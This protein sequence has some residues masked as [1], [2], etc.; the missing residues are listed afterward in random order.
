MGAE[1][2]LKVGIYFNARVEQGGLYQYALTLVDCLYRYVPEYDYLLYHA[3]LEKFP[4]QIL[5]DNWRLIQLPRLAIGFRMVLE[6]L[7]NKLAQFGL[8]FPL[9]LIPR[10]KQ[11]SETPPDIMVYVKPT[12]H[13]FEWPYGAIFPIHDLQHRL[14]PEFPEVSDH[15][16]FLRREFLYTHSIEKA[17]AI[18]TDSQTGKEDVL[19]LYSTD[20]SKIYPLPYIAPSFRTTKGKTFGQIKAQYV[21]PDDYFFYPAAFWSHKNHAR[22]ILALKQVEEVHGVAFH[23]V[24]SGSKQREYNKIHAMVEEL[25][26]S[27][28]V[29][30][31][32][33]VEEEDLLFLYQHALALVMP[34]FFGPTNIPILEAWSA[35]CS[36]ITSDIR[37]IREQ[38][39]DA[40]LLI[41]PR[42]ITALANALWTLSQ[43]Q[44]RRAVLIAKGT[45]RVNSWGA[46]D[47]GR[48]LAEIIQI[49]GNP[50][51]M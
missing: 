45:T 47:F 43:D 11:I 42:D 40:A 8:K 20:E 12:P 14:Q 7:L 25:H 22:L 39:G 29:H 34:T 36:V 44:K 33:F 48:R 41:D 1:G 46:S 9:K 21:L 23:L 51:K 24:L 17:K 3:T 35:G 15:G 5:A 37:G 31:I 30:F 10:F 38:A 49:A 19:H 18:L 13:V 2:R 27:E 4:M 26:L 6:V 32:G 16:E 50:S 28:N